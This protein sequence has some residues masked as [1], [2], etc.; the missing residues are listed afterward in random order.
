MLAL[1]SSRFPQSA[2]LADVSE[3]AGLH[4]GKRTS[5]LQVDDPS[6]INVALRCERPC[7][8]GEGCLFA[9]FCEGVL[10]KTKQLPP[11][12]SFEMMWRSEG[13]PILRC[14]RL[15]T[16]GLVRP[17]GL[18]LFR[19]R[20]GTEHA[21]GDD[22]CCV[23][24]VMSEDCWLTLFGVANHLANCVPKLGKGHPADH[25]PGNCTTYMCCIIHMSYACHIYCR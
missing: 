12:T 9:A 15:P 18:W 6:T 17:D 10:R 13:R 25:W 3:F 21:H 24:S 1:F 4:S 5:F 23:S 8:I 22:G 16:S 11:L 2:T 19:R 7:E 20:Y 14:F